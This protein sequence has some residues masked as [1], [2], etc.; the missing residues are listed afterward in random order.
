L[1]MCRRT[2]R[3]GCTCQFIPAP[4]RTYYSTMRETPVTTLVNPAGATGWAGSGVNPFFAWTCIRSGRLRNSRVRSILS[5][6]MRRWITLLLL[7]ILPIQFVWAG[8]GVQVARAN[9]PH[10]SGM[11]CYMITDSVADAAPQVMPGC[12]NDACP[13]M[14]ACALGHQAVV[15][16]LVFLLP[17]ATFAAPTTVLTSPTARSVPALFRPPI[18]SRPG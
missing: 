11:P 6:S 10:E 15:S 17:L 18:S 16:G 3:V 8:V 12:C 9:A 14:L 2:R 1:P 5:A 4:V 7:V 13:N